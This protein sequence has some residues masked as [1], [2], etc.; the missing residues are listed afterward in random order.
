MLAEPPVDPLSDEASA[1]VIRAGQKALADHIKAMQSA[2]EP[3]ELTLPAGI[4]DD[5]L[6]DMVN[7][8]LPLIQASMSQIVRILRDISRKLT[9]PE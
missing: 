4:L 3:V 2:Y 1:D 8:G 7:S 9:P 6:A 5:D